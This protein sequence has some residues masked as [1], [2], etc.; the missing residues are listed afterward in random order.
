MFQKH[1]TVWSYSSPSPVTTWDSKS[2]PNVHSILFWAFSSMAYPQSWPT[3]WFFPLI[4]KGFPC[5]GNVFM[6]RGSYHGML[7]LV[8]LQPLQKAQNNVGIFPV[9]HQSF[10]PSMEPLCTGSLHHLA[11]PPV[12]FPQL[13]CPS[14]SP[15]IQWH[16]VTASVSPMTC[17][18][19]WDDLD[20]SPQDITIPK[21]SGLHP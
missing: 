16:L 1:K 4:P 18:V 17:A 15:D 7:T 2:L 3:F 10:L 19:F 21:P 9:H 12:T 5:G 11:L 8:L 20:P 13:H 14:T 6:I